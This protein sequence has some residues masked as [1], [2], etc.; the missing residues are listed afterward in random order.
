MAQ[1]SEIPA[2]TRLL[3][4]NDLRGLGSKVA[5]NFEDLVQR[6]D[7]YVESVR[8]QVGEMLQQAESDVETIRREAQQPRFRT[9]AA[10]RP[11]PGRRD[12]PESGPPKSPKRRPATTWPRLFPR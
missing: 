7:A 6:G 9:G 11:P 12:D 2:Q 8:K 3:K 1:P 4:A 10:G 5:F